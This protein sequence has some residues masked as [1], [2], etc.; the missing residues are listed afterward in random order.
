MTKGA[1]FDEAGGEVGDVVLCDNGTQRFYEMIEDNRG[2]PVTI[3]VAAGADM[4]PVEKCVVRQ[5]EVALP[6]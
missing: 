4:Q 5:L 1:P 6:K 2:Q 3:R